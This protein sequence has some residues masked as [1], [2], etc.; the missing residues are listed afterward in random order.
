M[1]AASSL[2]DA[3]RRLAEAAPGVR[4]TISFAGS[5]RVAAQVR[6]GVLADVVATADEQT[7]ARLSRSGLLTG[8]P[9]VF[10][11]NRL[12]IAVRPGNPERVRG[13]ADLGRDDLDVVLAANN[14]PVGR[15]AA[16]VLR[17][18]GVRARPISLE[19]NVAAVSARVARGEADA[20]LVYVTDIRGRRGVEGVVI[21]SAHN[22]RARYPIAV[23]AAARDRGAAERFVR[24]VQSPEGQRILAGAGFGAPVR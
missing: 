16:Q 17:A 13:L 8:A 14:V 21:P 19:D 11:T 1:L 12:A 22:V 9:A 5:S 15:Y 18:T 23:L 2:Q 20:G 10:A 6:E 7:V 4:V 3:F 24:F